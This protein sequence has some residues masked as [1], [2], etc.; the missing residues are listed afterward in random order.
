MKKFF[1][2][3]LVLA[4]FVGAFYGIGLIVPRN[5]TQGSKTTTTAQPEQVFKVLSDPSTWSDWNPDVAS[6]REGPER[7]GHKIW[8]VTDKQARSYEMEVTLTEER[9]FQWQGSYTIEG[10]HFLLRFDVGWY[11]QGGRVSVTKTADTR[12]AWQ[13]ARRFLLPTKESSAL[14]LLNALSEQMGEAPS[15]KET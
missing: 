4:G 15:A 9:T 7:N 8:V 13:R 14:S 11:G 6:I 10:T 3:I 2:W 12:D 1:N 5:Q